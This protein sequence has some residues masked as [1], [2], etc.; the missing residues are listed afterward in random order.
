M[1]MIEK[2]NTRRFFIKSLYFVFLMLITTQHVHAEATVMLGEFSRNQLDGWEHKIFKGETRYQLETL[3]GI[4]V[5]KAES[6]AA[7]SGLFREQRID[8]DKTPVLN[9]SWRVSKR[10]K[11]LNEQSKS[12]DDYAARIYVVVKGG[13]A[14]WQT[15]AVNYVWS[16][17]SA[18]MCC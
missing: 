5:L 2:L 7:G 11:G 10:L 12:G 13:L 3:D 15:K 6:H 9:W 1:T 16:S 17:N 18:G 4:V 8:L 14:F